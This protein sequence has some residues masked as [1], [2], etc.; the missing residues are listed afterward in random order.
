MKRFR[1]CLQAYHSKMPHPHESVNRSITIEFNGGGVKLEL[2]TYILRDNNFNLFI[3]SIRDNLEQKIG[4]QCWASWLLLRFTGK[5]GSTVNGSSMATSEEPIGGEISWSE[6]GHWRISLK[7][8]WWLT[9]QSKETVLRRQGCSSSLSWG[10]RQQRRKKGRVLQ[11]LSSCHSHRWKYVHS[12]L[13]MRL[14]LHRLYILL[15]GVKARERRC[16]PGSKGSCEDL[17]QSSGT[18]GNHDAYIRSNSC[19]YD[20]RLSRRTDG[21]TEVFVVPCIYLPV[22]L[23]VRSVWMHF[24]NLSGKRSIG[25]YHGPELYQ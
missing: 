15:R 2:I 13:Q 20:L 17:V 19:Y 21:F 8:G 9:C 1:T 11:Q 10:R 7:V 25:T 24:G 16:T 5:N 12:K 14:H 18:N 23:D 22:S 4:Q 3:S 6:R